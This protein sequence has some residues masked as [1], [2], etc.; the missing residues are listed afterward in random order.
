MSKLREVL[1]NVEVDELD[2]NGNYHKTG[3]DYILSPESVDA[4][5]DAVIEA[6]P[7]LPVLIDPQDKSHFSDSAY[8]GTKARYNTLVEIK[9]LLLEAKENK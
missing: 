6:L 3:L 5:L 8:Y 2:S 4:I 1:N 7:E 9:E